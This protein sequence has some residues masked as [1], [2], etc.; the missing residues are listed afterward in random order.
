MNVAAEIRIRVYFS[1]IGVN[2]LKSIKTKIIFQT[3][4]LIFINEL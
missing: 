1:L 3:C 4:Q 2:Q